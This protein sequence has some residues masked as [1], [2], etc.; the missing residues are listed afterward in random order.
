MPQTEGSQTFGEQYPEV[1]ERL[2]VLR[3]ALG[4]HGPLSERDIRLVTLAFAIGKGLHSSITAETS[5]AQKA[6]VPDEELEQVALLAVTELGFS[7]TMNA[8]G[9]IN[10]RTGRGALR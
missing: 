3:D 6:G 1:F 8:L 10:P 2:Q 7:H 9:V 4:N 5:K